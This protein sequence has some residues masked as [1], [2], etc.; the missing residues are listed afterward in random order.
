MPFARLFCI[1]E[2]QFQY[3]NPRFLQDGNG[4]M[5][6]RDWYPGIIAD[7]LLLL[8]AWLSGSEGQLW[9][10]AEFFDAH[11][12]TFTALFTIALAVFTLF[13]WL[14]IAATAVRHEAV[15][16]LDRVHLAGPHKQ[17]VR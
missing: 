4:E 16:Q 8:V 1:A 2:S 12:G 3:N 14:R 15:V 13:L 7:G 17:R 10:V 6:K 11:N 5:L 9:R